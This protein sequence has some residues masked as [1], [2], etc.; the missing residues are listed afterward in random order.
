MATR[1]GRLITVATVTTRE[2]PRRHL[3]SF[4]RPPVMEVVVAI[5]SRPIS[6]LDPFALVELH[7][8]WSGTHPVGQIVPAAPSASA[9][10]PV[11]TFEFVQGPP[12]LRLWSLTEDGDSLI[13]VQDDRLVLNWR[14]ARAGSEYPRYVVMRREFEQFWQTYSDFLVQRF[15]REVEPATAE[16]TFINAIPLQGGREASDVVNLL[17]KPSLLGRSHQVAYQHVRQ[18]EGGE[19]SLTGTLVLNVQSQMDRDPLLRLA[20]TGRIDLF[21]RS[22]DP[23]QALDAAHEEVVNT[24][25]GVT[26][27]DMQQAWGRTR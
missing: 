22:V 20:I 3:P 7:K 26:T 25:V 6:E 17:A 14:K 23:L 9:D 4:E 11:P 18:L 5:E 1:E 8:Q 19:S 16:V 12:P 27:A 21:G 10:Q 24:F 13:Q 2:Q 15:G